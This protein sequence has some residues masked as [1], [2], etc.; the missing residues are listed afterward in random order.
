[1]Q[2]PLSWDDLRVFL[3]A[4]RQRSLAG[5]ARALGVNATTAG[6]RL[7]V[8]EESAR[9]RLFKRTV[10]GLVPTARAEAILGAIEIME[11]QSELVGRQIEGRDSSV[12]GLVRLAVTDSFVTNFL[13]AHLGDLSAKHPGLTLELVTSDRISDLGRGDADLAIRFTAPG[14]AIPVVSGAPVEILSRKVGTIA[15][16]VFASRA[17]LARRGRP[18]DATRLVGHDL[19]VPHTDAR[20]VPGYEWCRAQEAKGRVTL[21]TNS[22]NCL[23]AA[24]AAGLGFCAIPAYMQV[25]YPEL[26]RITPPDQVDARDLWLLMPED[27]VRVARVTAVRDAIVGIATHHRALLA[28][29]SASRKPR[30]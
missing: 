17:Y 10:D 21:R 11:R 13:G 3:A 23:A 12:E 26:E 18:T 28:G 20:L 27:L 25:H 6:R 24:A 5:A 22:P 30:R 4:Y 14:G 9:V 29:T 15:I 1:M 7:V 19:V 8:L 16:G 2:H